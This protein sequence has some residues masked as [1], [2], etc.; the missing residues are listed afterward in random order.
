MSSARRATVLFEGKAAKDAG[1]LLVPGK[2]L[3]WGEAPFK[4]RFGALTSL[5]EDLLVLASSI[6]ACDLAFKRGERENITRSI[7]LRVPVINF[8]GFERVREDLERILYVLSHD[9]WT[10]TF[11]RRQGTPEAAQTWPE[12]KGKT[13][14]FSGGL[15]SLAAAIDLLD[16][17]GPEKI[18]LA[19]HITG[20]QVTKG[21]QE[22][23]ITYLES[24][25]SPPPKRIALRTGGHKHADYDFPSDQEREETQRTRSFMFLTIAALAARRSGQSE[26]VM[27]AENGQM[28]IHLPLSAARI[29]SFSTHTAHP[30][31]VR[32]ASEVF[33]KLLEYN[34]TITNP[35]LYKTKAEVVKTLATKHQVAVVESVSCWRGSRVSTSNHCGECVPC[36]IRRIALEANGLKLAEYA[37][38]LLS[39]DVTVLKEDDE[40]KRNL[41]ELAEFSLAFKSGSPTDLQYL[42]PALINLHF[43]MDAAIAMYKRFAD[44]AFAVMNRY[45]GVKKL[46]PGAP[47]GATGKPPSKN[48]RRSRK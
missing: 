14:L 32:L 21:T 48:P 31:F 39:E 46:L 30:E 41:V 27:I 33:S 8:Q 12:S 10:L 23:L 1:L 24:K 26:V 47:P 28:A 2:N 36:L 22:K 38:D 45:A 17:Y 18:Q 25:Y 19:S 3:R 37:R 43:D 6:F 11:V 7:V 44:E 40:G 29:G 5:E 42:Y 9:N 16:Q 34:I 35:F 20:N 15:D 4:D 13:L